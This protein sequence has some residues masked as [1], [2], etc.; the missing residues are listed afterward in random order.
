MTKKELIKEVA[1]VTGFTQ[2]DVGAVTDAIFEGIVSGAKADGEVVIRDFGK[3]SV[4]DVAARTIRD[5]RGNGTIQLPA[6]KKFSFKPS[7]VVKAKIK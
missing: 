2:K 5:P 6:S 3:F 1:S 7:G 4:T